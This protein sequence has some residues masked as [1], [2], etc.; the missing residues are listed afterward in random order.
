VRLAERDRVL[1]EPRDLLE[2]SRERAGRR[3]AR[4]RLVGHLVQLGGH[5]ARRAEAR[6]DQRPQHDREAGEE[7]AELQAEREAHPRQFVTSRT[8]T[9]AASAAELSITPIAPGW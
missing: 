3:V 8:L 1:E 6:Q 9:R 7:Q 4:Q 5:L 2:A